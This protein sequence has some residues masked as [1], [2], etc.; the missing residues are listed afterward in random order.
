M[1]SSSTQQLLGPSRQ[2]RSRCR[3]E[4]RPGLTPEQAGMKGLRKRCSGRTPRD[5]ASDP[6]VPSNRARESPVGELSGETLRLPNCVQN[7][8]ISV[9]FGQL[10]KRDGSQYLRSVTVS[11]TEISL[12][13]QKVSLVVELCSLGQV[14]RDRFRRDQAK[15]LKTWKQSMSERRGDCRALFILRNCMHRS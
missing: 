5:K 7:D 9:D 12:R 3:K 6:C 11:D 2:D 8:R 14:A 15:R 10:R 13:S 4:L 1:E